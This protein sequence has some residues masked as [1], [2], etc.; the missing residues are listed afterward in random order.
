MQRLLV[1]E[2]RGGDHPESDGELALAEHD[3]SAEQE[4][5]DGGD[6]GGEALAPIA[7]PHCDEITGNDECADDEKRRGQDPGRG[8]ILREKAGGRAEQGQQGEGPQA[9]DVAG[10]LLLGL[11]LLALDAD[12]RAE[13]DGDGEIAGDRE[14][15]LLNSSPLSFSTSQLSPLYLPLAGRSDAAEGCVG[16]GG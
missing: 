8:Q 11:A 3:E 10:L 7:R 1:G 12:K 9:R 2:H 14:Q 15:L 6:L 16:V 5:D 4:D 13:Q